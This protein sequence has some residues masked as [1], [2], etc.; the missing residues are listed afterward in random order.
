MYHMTLR[1]CV[2]LTLVTCVIPQVYNMGPSTLPGSSVSISF[3]SRLSP[4]GAEMF[5]V[6]DMV[7]SPPFVSYVGFSFEVPV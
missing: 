5:Q 4:G 2:S 3:P 7:V 1:S 6:Q